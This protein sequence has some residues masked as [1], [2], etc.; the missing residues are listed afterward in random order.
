MVNFWE[1]LKV[2][3]SCKGSIAVKCERKRLS[4][5]T[6]LLGLRISLPQL[7]LL[8]LFF[9][10][11]FYYNWIPES[12]AW[13]LEN[14]R[15]E[16]KPQNYWVTVVKGAI[17]DSNYLPQNHCKKNRI[18]QIWDHLQSFACW[19]RQSLWPEKKW[20]D[21]LDPSCRRSAKAYLIDCRQNV[22]RGTLYTS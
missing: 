3:S 8:S 15:K 9:L 21:F 7:P 12:L 11:Q 17:S 19:I 16:V 5:N 1:N 13:P 22:R 18:F 4:H 20:C 2:N 6:S 10:S 14:Y